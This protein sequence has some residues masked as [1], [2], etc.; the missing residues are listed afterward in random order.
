MVQHLHKAGKLGLSR[1]ERFSAKFM[2]DVEV[3]IGMVSAEIAEKHIK[4]CVHASRVEL[5]HRYS[6]IDLALGTVVARY[7]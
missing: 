7:M 2:K 3:L 4:V 5:T 6:K 1:Q